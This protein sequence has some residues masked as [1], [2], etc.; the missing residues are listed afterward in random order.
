[1]FEYEYERPGFSVDAVLFWHDENKS[2]NDTPEVLLVKRKNEPFKDC[3]ALP[4]GFVER[5]ETAIDAVVRELYEETGVLVDGM[6]QVGIGDDP[7]RDPRGWTISIY[8]TN[9]FVGEKPTIKAGSDADKVKWFTFD[10][11]RTL[12]EN[13]QLA[14]DHEEMIISCCE[15]AAEQLVEYRVENALGGTDSK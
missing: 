5:H 12:I 11:L 10:E 9:V 1:M 2:V 6:Y 14:F 15:T 3:W 7:L 13:G 4:G 8:F